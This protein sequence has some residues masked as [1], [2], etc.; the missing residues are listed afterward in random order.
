[1]GTVRIFPEW[2][3]NTWDRLFGYRHA[4]D[5]PAVAV[6]VSALGVALAVT[7]LA[8]VILDPAGWLGSALKDD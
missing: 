3:Q 1:M 2:D 6:I 4:L 7:P 8:I 5:E